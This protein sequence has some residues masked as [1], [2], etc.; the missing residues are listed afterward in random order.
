MELVEMELLDV[1][2]SLE[3]V[4]EKGLMGSPKVL[5]ERMRT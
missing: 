3:E 1:E 2:V 4:L 5:E